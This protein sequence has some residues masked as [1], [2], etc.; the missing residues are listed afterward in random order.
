MKKIIL[1]LILPLSLI[2]SCRA[3]DTTPV[4]DIDKQAAG[5][6]RENTAAGDVT[7]DIFDLN[8]YKQSQ[9]YPEA[10]PAAGALD[11]K[12]AIIGAGAAG[13]SAAQYLKEKGYRYITIYE[14]ESRVGGKVYT[15]PVDGRL[16][17]LG[18]YWAGDTYPTVLELAKKFNVK[19]TIESFNQ[20]IETKPGKGY[21]FQK[22]LFVGNRPLLLPPQ[23]VKLA[24][25]YN[26]FGPTVKKP[27]L[28]H[29][30]PDLYLNMSTFAEKYGITTVAEIFE[31]F[32]IGCGYGYYKETPAIYVLKLMLPSLASSLKN[33]FTK[34]SL[35]GWDDGLYRFP[36]G[37]TTIFERIA[38]QFSDIRLSSPVVKV[39]R[40]VADGKAVIKVTAGG[41][42]DQYDR[43]IISTDLRA[44]ATFLD[45]TTEEKLLFSQVKSVTYNSYLIDMK[46]VR[47]SPDKIV[48]YNQ[49][50]SPDTAGHLVI[51]A[52][53]HP[54]RS[55]WSA[56]HTIPSTLSPEEGLRRLNSDLDRISS[57][58]RTIIK[59]V[60][61]DYFPH[62]TGDAMRAGFYDRIARLQ[63]QN[64]TYYIG[65]V[66]N[67]ETVESTS[68]FAKDLVNR[69]F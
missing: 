22:A 38:S 60:A 36:E 41:K 34:F 1:G 16:Y 11:Q 65:G 7:G 43:L 54:D 57:G 61:W 64:G 21:E 66:I 5:A 58:G 33:T 46:N 2:C 19:W 13:L 39:Q 44:A 26:L 69:M 15:V 20:W 59:K 67:F 29:I 47:Y 30:H 52:N 50:R 62:V 8:L 53:R 6:A 48:F 32:W 42:T 25:V 40:S 56:M 55:I 4:I 17:E 3:N 23:L 27:G 49:Y 24:R 35:E 45:I 12:I 28:D 37:Y 31:P 51:L 18:A 9:S 63:G 14:K 10:K 68:A